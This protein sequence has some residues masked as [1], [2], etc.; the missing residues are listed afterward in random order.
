M[1]IESKDLSKDCKVDSFDLS[2]E[3][4]EK[5]N[6][7]YSIFKDDKINGSLTDVRKESARRTKEVMQKIEKLQDDMEKLTLKVNG[8]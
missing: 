4:K 6:N 2:E 3:E 7:I 8:K 1:E 5:I